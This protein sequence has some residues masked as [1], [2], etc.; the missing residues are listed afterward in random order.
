MQKR[1]KYGLHSY[2]LT[3]M[4]MGKL[5]PVQLLEVLPGDTF[6]LQSSAFIRLQPMLAPV[7]HPVNIRLHHW[8]VPN[9]VLWDGWEDWIVKQ[10]VNDDTDVVPKVDSDFTNVPE[11]ILD[12]M[13][14]EKVDGMYVSMLP[15]AAY[16]LIYNEF[17]R[18]QDLMPEVP[19]DNQKVLNV[20][21]GKD[22]FTTARPWPQKG[23][24]VTLPLG[25]KAPISGFA[26]QDN[27]TFAT[28]DR[29]VHETGTSPTVTTYAKASGSSTLW[30]E[31]DPANPGYPNIYADLSESTGISVKE[32]R[33]Y[34]AV[35]RF[36]EARAQFGSRYSE[37][38]RYLGIKSRDSR[39]QRPEF[40]G[41][42]SQTVSMSEVLQ[43]AEGTNPVGTLRGHGIGAARTRR[44]RRFFE[45]HGIILTLASVVPKGIYMNGGDRLLGKRWHDMYW[46]KELEHIG[47]Q[48]I[49][50]YE[51]YMQ[52][53][54]AGDRATFGY[55]DRYS[56]YRNKRSLC[57]SEFRDLL[58][59]WH[60]GR[61][62]TEAPVLNESFVTCD[63][64]KRIFA[65]QTQHSLWCA[66]NHNT[67][68]RRMV[69]RRT[70]GRAS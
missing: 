20:A 56:D 31:E 39:L 3:T 29:T 59:Y 65:E 17:Y 18:D 61:K 50:N 16:N 58:D 43:T 52:G 40:L 35:Q 4:D 12:Y 26:T 10:P 23:P 70:I 42:G 27:A 14:M 25:S 67:V 45:E 32:L 44:S 21:W 7:M 24:E 46:Q 2:H 6:Q 54:A 57:T 1:N 8:Y 30:A 68:A 19:A 36:A 47:Q 53:L 37:Y 64:S 48:E 28:L 34:F 49:W 15:I 33:E 9:R 11:N 60:L 63:P 38:L 51:V 66:F 13:G 22:Y 5:V 55:Q 41:G 69:S 62:F